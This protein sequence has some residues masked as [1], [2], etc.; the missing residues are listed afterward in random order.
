MTY[1][2]TCVLLAQSHDSV[3]E[4]EVFTIRS[5]LHFKLEFTSRG[6]KIFSNR[7]PPVRI[8]LTTLTITESKVE[9]LS[10]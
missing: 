2:L 1:G 4:I 8:E 7:L 10:K 5:H 9:Y 6:L 3:N